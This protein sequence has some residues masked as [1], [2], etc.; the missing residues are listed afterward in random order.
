MR[1]FPSTKEAITLKRKKTYTE[2]DTLF[3]TEEVSWNIPS[4]FQPILTEEARKRARNVH[5]YMQFYFIEK[6]NQNQMSAWVT[7]M[8]YDNLK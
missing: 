4:D 6:K 7:T 8:A 3:R 2:L 1:T 5:L